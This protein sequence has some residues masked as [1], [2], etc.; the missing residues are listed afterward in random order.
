MDL[1]LAKLLLLRA[2]D[3]LLEEVMAVADKLTNE[4]LS[5]FVGLGAISCNGEDGDGSKANVISP[6][7]F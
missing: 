4:V 7:K 6:V 2:L 1:L 3:V 5:S